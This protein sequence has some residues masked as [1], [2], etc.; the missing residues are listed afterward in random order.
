MA[1]PTASRLGGARAEQ[2]LLDKATALRALAAAG[3]LVS[4][5]IAAGA[6]A[7]QL[8]QLLQRKEKQLII[9]A[10]QEPVQELSITVEPAP[11]PLAQLA[12]ADVAAAY[13]RKFERLR[14]L[15]LRRLNNEPPVGGSAGAVSIRTAQ[16]A[17]G[18]GWCIGMVRE[19]TADGFVLED[20]TGTL[21]VA[22]AVAVERDD[23]L[24]VRGTLHDQRLVATEALYPDIPLPTTVP[25][26]A[27][28]LLLGA[29]EAAGAIQLLL[30]QNPLH[31]MVAGQL[32][33]AAWKPPA[34]LDQRAAVALL[35]KRW[36]PLPP[37]PGPVEPALLDPA[38]DI[39]WL[40]QA[41]TPEEPAAPAFVPS[42]A[43]PAD[44]ALAA[45]A[46]EAESAGGAER[47]EAAG[48]PAV[49]GPGV[50]NWTATYKAVTII[51]AASARVDLRTRLVTFPSLSARSSA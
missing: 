12:I 14:D 16:A 10:L 37:Q 17:G 51:A 32:R 46:A 1:M 44:G 22:S 24:A 29:G 34:P 6:S 3:V 26:A 50:A 27:G 8:A 49:S 38:P 35:Q 4:P 31:A 42:K 2:T 40:V 18:E 28:T 20:P 7:A 15:L 47:T 9:T 41:G 21:E 48:Q 25:A 23:V 39:L 13:Q 45:S 36:L 43:L 5:A 11:P 19:P 33:I 30:Q